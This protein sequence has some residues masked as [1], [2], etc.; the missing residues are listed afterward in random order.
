MK[1]TKISIKQVMTL[2]LEGSK[3]LTWKH[4][5]GP[6]SAGG[7]STRSKRRVVCPT[8]ELVNSFLL[9]ANNSPKV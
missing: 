6:K 8:R 2:R 5:G 3:I 1:D 9:R 4:C 7:L